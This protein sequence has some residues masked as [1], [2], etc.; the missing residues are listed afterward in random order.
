MP[1]RKPKPRKNQS[2][3]VDRSYSVVAM[4]VPIVYTKEGDHDPNGMAYVLRPVEV[5]LKWAKQRWYDGDALLARLHFRRQRAQIVVDGLERL[6]LMIERL[7]QGNDDDRELLAELI[8]RE[9]HAR[10]RRSG[11][12]GSAWSAAQGRQGSRC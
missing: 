3:K 5:L 1:E 9:I 7:R 8:Q 2:P 6:D 12:S 10:V 4:S 11:R